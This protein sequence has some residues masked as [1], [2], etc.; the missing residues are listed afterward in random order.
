MDPALLALDALQRSV[1]AKTVSVLQA[2]DQLRGIIH[3]VAKDDSRQFFRQIF[4]KLL[5]FIIGHK[6]SLYNDNRV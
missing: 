1:E 4:P 6:S 5:H 3:E 2:C